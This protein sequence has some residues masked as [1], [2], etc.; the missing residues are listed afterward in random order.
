MFEFTEEQRMAQRMLRQWC[1]A[2]LAPKVAA[3][4]RGELLPYELMRKLG[5]TFQ[6][7]EI[8]RAS[9]QRMDAKAAQGEESPSDEE[10]DAGSSGSLARDPAMSAILAIELSRHC[11]GFVLA[12]GASLGL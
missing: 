2:E 1:E 8:V 3:M 6:L 12:F 4:E 5:R 7:D 9:F 11:P 10:E